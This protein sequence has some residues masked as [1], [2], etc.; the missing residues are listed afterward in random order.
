MREKQAGT[1]RCGVTVRV[2]RAE[3]LQTTTS[4]V[5]VAPLNAARTA[6][7]AVPA[8]N[9]ARRVKL[10]LTIWL[11]IRS[12]IQRRDLKRDIDEELRFHVDRR[13]AD[14]VAAGMSP[15]E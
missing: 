6:Q 4:K 9:E 13:T 3:L 1:T 14:N 8:P 12:L 7:R 10:M 2:Q 11:R 15:E 5:R